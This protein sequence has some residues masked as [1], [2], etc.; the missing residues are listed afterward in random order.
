DVRGPGH[1]FVDIFDLAGNKVKRLTSHGPLNSP[2]GLAIAPANFGQFSNA[3]LVGNFG[4]GHINAFDPMTGT[5]LGHMLRPSGATLEI[6]GLWSLHFGNGATAGPTNTLLFTAGPQD[7]SH[8]LFGT[9][10]LPGKDLSFALHKSRRL[11]WAFF[12]SASSDKT[13]M[14]RSHL[15][16][17]TYPRNH[18]PRCKFSI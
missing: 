7:E 11:G 16:N 1:G 17:L 4:N 18:L 15:G 5:P 6:N 8:G 9:I 3:L 2:W 10:T 13:A 12:F 14:L